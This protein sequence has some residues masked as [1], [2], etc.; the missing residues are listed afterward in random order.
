[1]KV[2]V[3]AVLGLVLFLTAEGQTREGTGSRADDARQELLKLQGTWQLES[4]EEAKKDAKTVTKADVKGRTLFVG[5]EVFLMRDGERVVQ[6]GTLR[7]LPAKR[8][9][10]AVVRKGEYEGNT[11]LGVYE[12]KGDT[13]RVCF[14]PEGDGRPKGFAAKAGSGL[15]VAVYKR[16]KPA[17]ETGTLIGRYR[18]ESFG[19]DG[20]KQTSD[21]EIQKHGDAYL[22]RWT[23]GRGL[24]YIGVGIRKGETFSVAWANRGTVGVSVYTIEKGSKLVGIYTEVGGIGIIAKEQLL[25]ARTGS[26]LEVRADRPGR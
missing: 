13:L 20:R 25:P 24:A 7:L 4:L 10:D 22:V 23:L 6:A 14:D 15:L 17:G 5:S 26:R 21:A 3:V 1:M 2:R 9:V 16:V 18:C 19:A 11:M 8:A 12:L